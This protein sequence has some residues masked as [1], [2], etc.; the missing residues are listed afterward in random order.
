MSC[1]LS[2]N[3]ALHR[4]IYYVHARARQGRASTI[5]C[6]ALPTTQNCC[7]RY[8]FNLLKEGQR[9]SRM[10]EKGECQHNTE[11]LCPGPNPKS[12]DYCPDTPHAATMLSSRLPMESTCR[13]ETVT[14]G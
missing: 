1:V 2:P 14:I 7:N 3:W 6:L 11:S 9:V 8:L 4:C 12:E 5:G 13:H 10:T